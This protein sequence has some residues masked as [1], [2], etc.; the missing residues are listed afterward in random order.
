MISA[1]VIR[2][3]CEAYK[4]S[5]CLVRS[6]VRVRVFISTGAYIH[7]MNW[8]KLDSHFNLQD[9]IEE[10]RSWCF[11][12]NQIIHSFIFMLSSDNDEQ[13]VDG[14]LVSSDREKVKVMYGIGLDDFC[15][16][17]VQVGENHPASGRWRIDPVTGREVVQND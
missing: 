5:D 16:Y 7:S 12:C 15:S 11:M 13:H 3:L 8:D 9:H 4:I 14:F 2:K 10:S 6:D 17:A 1:Y